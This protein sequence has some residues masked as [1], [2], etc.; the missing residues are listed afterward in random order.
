MMNSNRLVFAAIVNLAAVACATEDVVFTANFDGSQQ[1]YVQTLPENFDREKQTDV[2]IALHGHGGDRWQFIQQKRDECR[3]VRDVARQRG[4]IL[5]SPDYRASTSWMGPAAEA[6]TLQII[7]RLKKQFQ[8]RRVIL[9]G[10]SMGGASCLTFAALHPDLIDGVVSMNGTANHVEYEN[11]QDAIRD[12]FG[13][14]KSSNSREYRKRSAELWAHRFTMPTAFTTGGKDT[15]VPPTSVLRLAA[16]LKREGRRTLLLHRELGGHSTTHDD[17]VK[18]LRFVL[19]QA[20]DSTVAN[21]EADLR[22]TLPPAFYAAPGTESGIY[23]DNIVLTQTPE[24]Y[25]FDVQCDIGKVEKH[26]WT[27]T[28]TDDDVG[29]HAMSITVTDAEGTQLGQASTTLHVAPRTA[30]QDRKLSMLIV[31]DSLTHATTYPNE[32]ARRLSEPGNPQWTM[33]GTHKPRNATDGVRH[34]GYGGWTWRHFFAKYEPNP[35]GTHRKRSSPFVFLNSDGKPQLDVSRYLET[36]ADGQR[37][38]IVFFLLGINDCFGANPDDRAAIDARIDVMLTHAEILLAEFRKAAPQTDLAICITTPPNA[39][40]SGFEANY[41]GRYHR[42]GWKR[43]Q[44][45]L[46]ERLQKHFGSQPRPIDP[47]LGRLYVTPTH[48]NLD[49]VAGYPENNGVHPNAFGYRQIGESFYCWLK[50]RMEE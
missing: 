16:E 32:L 4:M 50:W 40:E 22:L 10:A 2:L 5:I 36:T 31:G 23:F 43:I 8:V 15:S 28:P 46:V 34:E 42:W 25:R 19:D 27:V 45:R 44:H 21:N 49:P 39:R 3:A 41:K 9:C 47:S 20:E 29:T 30:G 18:A 1:R 6:D 17:A 48:L 38:D 26:R 12:S 35:D 37:P 33:L 24:N 7:A 13:G 11:F 14:P